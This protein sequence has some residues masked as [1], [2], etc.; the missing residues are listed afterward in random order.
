MRTK[1]LIFKIKASFYKVVISVV[2]V[3]LAVLLVAPPSTADTIVTRLTIS[4][5][6]IGQVAVNPTNNKVYVGYWA[7][8]ANHIAV[9]DGETNAILKTLN[10]GGNIVYEGIVINPSTNNV[11]VVEDSGVI[12]RLLKVQWSHCGVENGEVGVHLR[13]G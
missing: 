5:A 2:L 6:S 7:G 3:L 4:N 10:V 8:G 9:V 11:Y 13:C 1:Q 12:K